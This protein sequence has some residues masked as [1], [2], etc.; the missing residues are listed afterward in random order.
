MTAGIIE[1]TLSFKLSTDVLK[2]RLKDY[3]RKYEFVKDRSDLHSN[4]WSDILHS[5]D[6]RE[7]GIVVAQY[8]RY[9]EITKMSTSWTLKAS[10]E[11]IPIYRLHENPCLWQ[12]V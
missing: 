10:T 1:E 7:N 9:L 2:I 11:N 12:L 5:S 3:F 8:I 6:I 4:L